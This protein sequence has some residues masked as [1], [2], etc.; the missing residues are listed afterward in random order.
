MQTLLKSVLE[1]RMAFLKL[2]SIV[3]LHLQSA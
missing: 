1:Y 2:S 3:D